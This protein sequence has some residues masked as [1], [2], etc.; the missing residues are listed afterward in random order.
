MSEDTSDRKHEASEQKIARAREKGQIPKSTDILNFA[1]YCGLCGALVVFGQG[2]VDRIGVALQSL[3]R[4]NDQSS[5]VVEGAL[6]HSLM[7]ASPV[8]LVPASFI[9][10]ALV[11]Q[12]AFVFTPEKVQPKLSRISIIENVKQK[13]GLKGFVE[14][15]K[16][17]LKLIVFVVLSAAFMWWFRSEIGTAFE[18][19]VE[20]GLVLMTD[21]L[22]YFLCSVLL[23]VFPIAVADLIWQRHSFAQDQRMTDK[24]MRDEFKENEGDPQFK[25]V[26]RQRG[27]EIAMNRMLSDVPTS[28]VV[29]VNPTHV[30]VAL[31]WDRQAGTAPVCVAKGHDEI[32]LKIRTIALESGVPLH[33]DP[34]AARAIDAGVSIGSEIPV[35]LYSA[36]AAAIRYADEMRQRA[37]KA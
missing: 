30:A 14:F 2:M 13:F 18:L 25:Q 24:E 22:I 21:V 19:P 35:E 15:A 17:A 37:R 26:R 6:L 33:K 12:R 31:K 5:E 7:S 32:A 29:M 28:D 3:W 4:L 10:F 9:V 16:S 34:P 36:V 1:G 27:R 8:F 20:I 23:I 11:F